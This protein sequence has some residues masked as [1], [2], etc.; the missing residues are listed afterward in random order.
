MA[1][2]VFGVGCSHSPLLATKPEQWELRANDDRK[3]PAHPFRGKVYTFAELE[4]LRQAENLPEQIR[5]DVRRERDAR[6]QRSLARLSETIRAAK[7]DV[8]VAPS[9]RRG[10][11]QHPAADL[12]F[13]DRLE[14]RAEI[15][16]AEALVA[17]ALDELEE[18]RPEH[19]AG[20][21]L[22][23]YLGQAAVN[24][25]FAVDQHA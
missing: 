18:D 1:E 13:L 5:I 11:R 4:R 20:E 15:A 12:I 24:H 19:G 7:L 23:Q 21:Y 3:N 22:Q 2:I 10:G 17:L 9:L 25:A 8:L 6:N 16:L 14:Q